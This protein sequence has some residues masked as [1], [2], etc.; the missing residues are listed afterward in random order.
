M[1]ANA[2]L[3][4]VSAIG[5]LLADYNNLEVGL[6][7]CVQFGINDFDFAF[8]K[9]FGAR[10]ETARIDIAEKLGLNAFIALGLGAEFQEGVAAIRHALKIRNQYAHWTWWDDFTGQ[11]A[12]ANLEDLAKDT[13]PIKDFSRLRGHHVSESLLSQ[14]SAFFAYVDLCLTWV[15][16][17]TQFLT[18]KSATRFVKPPVVPAPD[19]FHL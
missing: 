11:L 16:Q 17:E 18:G 5:H 14:Q 19:L 1:C 12:I 4:E 13:Q 10:G 2:R 15:N 7:L 6:L 3:K 9:M 8:K